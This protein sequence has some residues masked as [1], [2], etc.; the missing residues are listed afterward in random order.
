MIKERKKKESF[1]TFNHLSLKHI[2]KKSDYNTINQN[3]GGVK[4]Q[5][6]LIVEQKNISRHHLDIDSIDRYQ[7]KILQS[8]TNEKH[9]PIEKI[10]DGSIITLFNKTPKP[11][12]L[13]DVVCPHFYELKWANG[14]NYNCA[15]CYLNG[16][17]RFLSRGKKPYL[18]DIN[19]TLSHLDEF[20]Q[21]VTSHSYLLNSGELSDSLLFENDGAPI[22]NFIIPKFV[23]QDQHKLLILTKSNNVNKLLK[24]NAQNHIIISFS[25][26]SFKVSKRW[27]KAPLVIDRIKAAKRLYD[28]GYQIRARIDPMV[29]IDGWRDDYIL[30]VDTIFNNFIPERITLGSLRG[31]QSTINNSKDVSWTK[32]LTETSNWGKKIDIKN[33]LEMYSNIIDH[34][35]TKYEYDNIALCKETIDIWNRM[36]LNYKKIKCNCVL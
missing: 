22:S 1:N 9:F 6:E 31:L 20:F 30:L 29:P 3:C 12:N 13:T 35:K 2:S 23:A 32:Y 33:R 11:E 16:T 14:C 5:S 21:T 28:Q 34:L 24:S 25:F 15:W 8:N 19:T 18:K 4:I 10:K 26:N 36:N 17:Y 7:N 27:E